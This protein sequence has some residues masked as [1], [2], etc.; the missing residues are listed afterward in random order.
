M[1]HAWHEYR[2]YAASSRRG[3]HA[4]RRHAFESTLRWVTN[5]DGACCQHPLGTCRLSSPI[6]VGED[7]IPAGSRSTHANLESIRSPCRGDGAKFFLSPATIAV[8]QQISAGTTQIV[9]EHK[10]VE[11]AQSFSDVTSLQSAASD[12]PGPMC[13]EL[14][15]S[16]RLWICR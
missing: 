10:S 14:D 4:R 9:A 6:L 11:S 16:Q 5:L 15:L 1:R 7:W 13:I 2:R 12:G 8:C 3:L